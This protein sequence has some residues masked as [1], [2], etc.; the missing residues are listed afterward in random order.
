MKVFFIL[1]CLFVTVPGFCQDEDIDEETAQNLEN[2]AE[3]SEDVLNEGEVND[4]LY[5][6][7]HRVNLNTADEEELKSLNLLSDVQIANLFLY[8]K[9]LGPL[10]HIYELQAI[11]LWDI[12]T[13]RRLLPMVSIES[14][15]GESLKQAIH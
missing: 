4:Y 6:I 7:K 11:P 5:Y 9:V 3:E 2:I 15:G 13:I 12:R 10:I 1:L 14:G 8:R